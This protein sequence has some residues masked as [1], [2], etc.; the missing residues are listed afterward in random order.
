MKG[1]TVIT[2]VQSFPGNLLK[3]IQA[4]SNYEL[5]INTRLSY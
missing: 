2:L 5:P 4:N 3:L 1:N